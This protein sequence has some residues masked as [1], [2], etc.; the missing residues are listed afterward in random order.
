MATTVHPVAEQSGRS[1]YLRPLWL[2]TALTVSAELIIFLIWGVWLYPDGNL[3]Y[4]FLWAVV[5]CGIGMGAVVGMMLN[6]IVVDR[7][8]GWKAIAATTAISIVVLGV[9]CD[10]LCLSLDNVFG[11]FGGAENPALFLGNGLIMSAI[12]GLVVGYLL[13]TQKGEAWL[14]KVVR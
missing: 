14:D 13:F 12:G 2:V 10:T 9:I 6:M 4:K 3:L 5:F 7:W 11:Y 1:R 8:Q